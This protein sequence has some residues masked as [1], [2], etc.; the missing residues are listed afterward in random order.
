MAIKEKDQ[1]LGCKED[2]YCSFESK[3]KTAVPAFVEW[4]SWPDVQTYTRAYLGGV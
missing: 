4:T 3:G 2:P 1:A